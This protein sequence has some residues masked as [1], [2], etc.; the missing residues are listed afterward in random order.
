M[1]IFLLWNMR[2]AAE[3]EFNMFVKT[4]YKFVERTFFLSFIHFVCLYTVYLCFLFLKT[5]SGIFL[6]SRKT[7]HT[8]DKNN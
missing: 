8:K 5:A 6:Q 1:R 7:P 3:G 2:V 4:L